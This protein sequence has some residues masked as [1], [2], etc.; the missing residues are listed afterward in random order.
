MHL[1]CIL[2]VHDKAHVDLV[3]SINLN[4]DMPASIQRDCLRLEAIVLQQ[5]QRSISVAVQNPQ[6]H[7]YQ[8]LLPI[9]VSAAG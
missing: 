7:F 3:G 4:G 8:H 5:Q 6:R 2:I 9:H 1:L